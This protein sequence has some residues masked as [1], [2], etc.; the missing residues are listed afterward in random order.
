ML[1]FLSNV[2]APIL[3][4]SLHP[5]SSLTI[6]FCAFWIETRSTCVGSLLD[7]LTLPN[8]CRPYL[9][10]D[11]KILLAVQEVER[12]DVFE[13][14]IYCVSVMYKCKLELITY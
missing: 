8:N 1:T 5:F 3:S 6:L 14:C 7:H 9:I 4:T 13:N 10:L 11:T 12:V 2:F